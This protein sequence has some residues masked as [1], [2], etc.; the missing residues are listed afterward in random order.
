MQSSIAA[1]DT[2]LQESNSDS[3]DWADGGGADD[4]DRLLGMLSRQEWGQLKYLYKSRDAKWRASL[5]SVLRPQQG[6]DAERLMLDLA[7]D[8]DG[9]VAFL[10]VSSIAF[11]CGINEAAKGP[12]IDLKIRIPSFLSRAKTTAGLADQTRRVSARCHTHLQR[13]LEFFARLLESEV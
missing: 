10:A 13:R 9:E 1:F 11:Y 2:F 12:F 7:W 3:M 8:Q 6:E 4:A 5:A